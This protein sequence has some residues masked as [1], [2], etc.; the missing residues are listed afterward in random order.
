MLKYQYRTNQ[1]LTYPLASSSGQ[2]YEREEMV[3]FDIETT[4]FSADISS[5]YLIGAAYYD[6]GSWHTVQWFAD[7]YISEEPILLEFFEFLSRF[8]VLIHYNGSGFDL[9]YLLKKCRQY[10]LN[11]DFTHLESLDLYKR[12][13]PYK[14]L[15][16]LRSLRLKALEEAM[17]LKRCDERDGSELIPVYSEYLKK[18]FMQQEGQEELRSL[19]LLHNREDVE[20]LL[21]LSG[22]LSTTD[23]LEQAPRVLNTVRSGNLVTLQ[24]QVLNPLMLP[25]SY[26]NEWICFRASEHTAALTVT[27]FEGE[28]KYFYQDYKNYYYLPLEDQ[29][30]HKSIAAY[31]DKECKVKAKAS[32]CYTKKSSV[33]LP[34][35]KEILTPC[36][37]SEYRDK[38][39]YFELEGV[40]FDDSEV[41]GRY[42]AHLL[43]MV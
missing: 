3:F 23:L 27:V 13:L 39:L 20:N 5:L 4:G 36:F 40:S 38:K 33:F 24:L 11:K 29:A 31:V 22:V 30:I 19:L 25:I 8:R 28:L 37:R 1:T 32:N 15:I 26:E 18:K 42:A 35:Q 7:D 14:K 10:H 16:N 12:I 2:P 17:G 43:K 21:F 6:K 34:Q 41:W 9:P